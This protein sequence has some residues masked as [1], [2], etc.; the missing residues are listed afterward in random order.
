MVEIAIYYLL[1]KLLL[2]NLLKILVLSF[3]FLTNF[4]LIAFLNACNQSVLINSLFINY[5][6]LCY[7]FLILRKTL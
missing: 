5:F 1:L 3:K 6:T 2:T 7:S 4:I